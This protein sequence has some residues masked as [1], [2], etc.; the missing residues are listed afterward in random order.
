MELLTFILPSNKAK[1]RKICCLIN[2]LMLRK[3]QKTKF[4]KKWTKLSWDFKAKT[5]TNFL[6]KDLVIILILPSK[7]NPRKNQNILIKSD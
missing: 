2:T 7:T 4:Q 1:S 3:V 6:K 5:G